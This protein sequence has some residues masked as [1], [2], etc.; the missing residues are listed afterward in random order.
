MKT[1]RRVNRASSD[2]AHLPMVHHMLLRNL[3]GFVSTVT[4]IRTFG[5]RMIDLLKGI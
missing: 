1:S 2:R 5:R 3:Y 4:L